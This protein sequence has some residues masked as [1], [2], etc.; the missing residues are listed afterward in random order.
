MRLPAIKIQQKRLED[1]RLIHERL[2]EHYLLE[3]RAVFLPAP[4]QCPK[5]VQLKLNRSVRKFW[6]GRGFTLCT[7][8]VGIHLEV[9]LVPR[10]SSRRSVAADEA[11]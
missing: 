10:P 9:W 6:E 2:W 5:D 8:S 11:A 3:K 4:D 1:T 7:R